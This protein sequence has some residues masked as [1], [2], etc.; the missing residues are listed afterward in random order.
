MPHSNY[1]K[2]WDLLTEMV[3][4]D[5]PIDLFQLAEEI[6]ETKIESFAIWRPGPEPGAPP[7][8]T[9][10]SPKS[11]RRLIRFASDLRLVNIEDGRRCSLTPE[12]RRAQ[13]RDNYGRA[14]TTQLSVYLR[15]QTGVTYSGIKNTITSIRR[16]DVPFFET[17]YDRLS[18]EQ[19]LQIGKNR[20]RMVLYLMERC[21]MLTSITR[22]L[23]FGPEAET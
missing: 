9:Y 18:R 13:R 8:K 20:L 14:M 10:C 1:S 6:H 12:G 4:E 19:E 15:E 17:I 11:I 3:E 21:G 2:I 23:Y 5:A 7:V 16:P 22:K